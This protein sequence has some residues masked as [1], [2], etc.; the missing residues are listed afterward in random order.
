MRGRCDGSRTLCLCFGCRCAIGALLDQESPSL[1]HK[2]QHREPNSL[3]SSGHFSSP[4]T[5]DKQHPMLTPTDE[6]ARSRCMTMALA[7]FT[8]IWRLFPREWN[9]KLQVAM[10]ALPR[11]SSDK[12]SEA[13]GSTD[14]TAG[15]RDSHQ[16]STVQDLVELEQCSPRQ[17]HQSI[18]W[19]RGGGDQDA[20]NPAITSQAAI[21]EERKGRSGQTESLG[22]CI[23][24]RV[25]RALVVFFIR[26]QTLTD[27]EPAG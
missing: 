21:E 2:L 12:N 18:F 13:V 24:K 5:K 23:S 9:L 4:D 11:P 26:A 7:G 15:T 27:R 17:V 3:L 10:T 1:N 16:P 14:K 8:R 20:I 25:N 19:G 6:A 22:I